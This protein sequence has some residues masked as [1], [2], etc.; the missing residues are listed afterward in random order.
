[1]LMLFNCIRVILVLMRRHDT[2]HA[3]SRETRTS[4]VAKKKKKDLQMVP[5]LTKP[6]TLS[7]THT[8]SNCYNSNA[9][10]KNHAHFAPAFK[11]KGKPYFIKVKHKEV[12]KRT[13]PRW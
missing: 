5:R 8:I 11:E 13:K 12:N 3:Y 7:V 1:M 2:T 6:H 9:C 4:P 10:W